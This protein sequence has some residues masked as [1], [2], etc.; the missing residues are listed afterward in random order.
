MSDSDIK[1][2]ASAVAEAD[3]DTRIMEGVKEFRVKTTEGARFL[4]RAFVANGGWY[5]GDK[6]QARRKKLGRAIGKGEPPADPALQ[7]SWNVKPCHF[8]LSD[9]LREHARKCLTFFLSKG[10][11]A[12]DLD[13]DAF[14]NLMIELG[15]QI[16]DP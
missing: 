10:A 3:S 2:E 1:A 8:W 15:M 14:D 12:N 9:R 5:S 7:A 13:D 6:E 4:L 11:I 16:T